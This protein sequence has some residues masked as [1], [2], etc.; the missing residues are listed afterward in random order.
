MF[1]ITCYPAT[2]G[3]KGYGSGLA[4][5]SRTAALFD[6]PYLTE[7]CPRPRWVILGLPFLLSPKTAI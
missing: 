5:P 6:N 2:C 7:S 4:L 1:S 3:P